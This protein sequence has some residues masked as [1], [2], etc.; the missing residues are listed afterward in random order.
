LTPNYTKSGIFAAQVFVKGIPSVI[1]VDDFFQFQ[2]NSKLYTN[3]NFLMWDGIAPDGSLWG[4]FL[5]KVWAKFSGSFEKIISGLQSEAFD[6]ILGTP[7]IYYNM[8]DASTIKNNYTIA[9]QTIYAAV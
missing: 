7:N 6:F 4:P 8:S 1:T 3:Y 9:F 2:S 5:E